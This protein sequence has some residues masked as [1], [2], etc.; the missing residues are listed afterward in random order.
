MR[1]PNF[2]LGW[3]VPDQVAALTHFHSD[4]T[5][6][7]FM[8]VIQAGVELLAEANQEFHVIIDNRF[9]EMPAPVPL[10]Q[11]QA[12]VPYMK[13]PMLRWVVV[14]KPESLE[15]DTTHLPIEQS[16]NVQLINVSS[17]QEA[18]DQLQ[19]VTSDVSWKQADSTFF[20]N[21]LV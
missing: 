3:Y 5:Q 6:E 19:N 13:H 12:M 17:L 9:V 4:V 20:P 18:F 8:G 15:L 14:V 1:E 7:D 21:K 16:G 10:S 11:M 2:K